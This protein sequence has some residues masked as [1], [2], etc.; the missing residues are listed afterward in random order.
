[1]KR[2]QDSQQELVLKIY[3]SEDLKSYQKE[4]AVFQKLDEQNKRCN[5]DG[6]P[7]HL[8]G[9]PRLISFL[10]GPNSTEILM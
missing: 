4:I 1:V 3:K 7:D 8:V 6:S 9:F 5:A 2:A 10:E